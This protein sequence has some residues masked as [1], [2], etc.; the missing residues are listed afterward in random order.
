MS[1]VEEKK[2]KKRKSLEKVEVSSEDTPGSEKKLKKKKKSK[3][4]S[5][6]DAISEEEES[7]G[8][9]MPVGFEGK[10][11]KG[12][13]SDQVFAELPI[14]DKTKDAL[15]ELGFEKMTQIQAKSIPDALAGKDLLGAAK[16][17]SG[18]TLAFLVPIVELLTKVNFTRKQG[19]GAIVISP[20]RE[21]SLQ[22]YGVLR[23]LIEQAGHPQ[24]HGLVMGGANRKAEAD[25][26][27]KGVNIIVA[28][29]GR[30][31]DHL[32]NTKGFNYQRLQML[33]I[34]EADRILDQGFEEDMHTIIKLVPKE[35]QTILFS[36]TQT[37]KVEDLARLSI[38]G[39]PVYVGVHDEDTAATVAGLQQGYVTCPSEKRFQ[40]LFTF[41]KK[42]KNKKVMVFFSSCNSVQFHSELLNYIDIEV[43]AIHGKQK[44]QKRTTTFFQFCKQDKGILCCTD[45]AAR[46][47]DIPDVDWIVQYDPPDDPKEYIHR[48]G[49][50]ARGTNNQ[51]RALL[52]LLPE[53]TAFLRYLR[54]AKVELNEYEF[55]S[56]KVA[57]IGTQM[58]M[59]IEKNY[60][61]NKSARDAYRSYLLAYAS[62][63]HKDIF[64][65]LELDL[66]GVG[67]GFGFSVPPRVDLNLSAR[68]PEK[69]GRNKLKKPM[70][71]DGG[72]KE[73][74]GSSGH[75]FSA[76]NPYGK[77]AEGDKRQFS[78]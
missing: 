63:S 47:L 7:S 69:R 11:K 28:T 10:Q 55:P 54:L 18:K 36:A 65:V 45:V 1:S 60:Y 50:T 77:R 75:A 53:E 24:T 37:K 74:F 12:I 42:N 32:S 38:K 16:T 62:H 19:T 78:R 4:S 22:I 40:L 27:I 70:S 49:R 76:D 56:S 5:I 17:G 9:S 31:V 43:Q 29:P 48:V 58:T 59:L 61:L 13:F 39:T 44:Q 3:E 20:T 15:K 25:K 26:L 64:K 72:R 34:D 6:T 30:L 51:G 68:G 57:N 14:G 71:A 23:D 2:S 41:L 67:K 33:V 35:R 8:K 21:L 73:K 46:G 66:Q 52:F